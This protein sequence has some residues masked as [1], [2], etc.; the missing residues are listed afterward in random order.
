[1][2]EE[3]KKHNPYNKNVQTKKMCVYERKETKRVRVAL[4][5]CLRVGVSVR[6]CTG[7]I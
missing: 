1:M 6:G 7:K 2:S 4:M 5:V 3:S